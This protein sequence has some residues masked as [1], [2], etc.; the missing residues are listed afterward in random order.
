M[1][2]LR[3]QDNWATGEHRDV[4]ICPDS[5]LPKCRLLQDMESSLM[6][7]SNQNQ[8]DLAALRPQRGVYVRETWV[9][10][11]SFLGGLS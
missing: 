2:Y 3:F 1:D 8:V 7:V 5:P 11:D 6:I 4:R 10:P 9:Q